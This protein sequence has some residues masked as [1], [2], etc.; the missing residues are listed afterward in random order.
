M[1]IVKK[2]TCLLFGEGKKD[3]NFL[4]AL[5][6]LEQFKYQTKLWRISVSN[7]SGGTA[8]DI[9]KKCKQRSN[10]SED[11]V[12]CFIDLDRLKKGEFKNTLELEIAR[13]EQIA[14]ED[15]IIIIWH[16]DD[17][18]DEQIKVVGLKHK[19]KGKHKINKVAK[20][21]IEK[22]INSSYWRKIIEPIKDKEKE[23]KNKEN[24]HS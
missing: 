22:F 12:L 3:K 11:L 5:V 21:Q 24:Q 19:N 8:K 13:L 17:L 10:G 18:E 6:E 16:E 9:L 20:E 15:S 2:Y 23:I 1:E 7:A 4:Y 14:L